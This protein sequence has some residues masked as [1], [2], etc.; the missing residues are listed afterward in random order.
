MD[1][2]VVYMDIDDQVMDLPALHPTHR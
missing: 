2:H 1:I